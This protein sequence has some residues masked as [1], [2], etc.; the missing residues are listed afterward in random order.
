MKTLFILI[1]ATLALSAHAEV[2][3]TMPNNA[4]GEFKLTDL[5]GTCSPATNVAY[6]TNPKGPVGIG[7]W[8]LLDDDV[9][10]DF[11]NGR[12]VSFKATDFTARERKATSRKQGGTL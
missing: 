10:I 9:I 4:G 2:I 5:R 8:F 3:A 12:T 11:P 6:T 1:A 7:C